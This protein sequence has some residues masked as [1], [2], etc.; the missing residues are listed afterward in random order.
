MVFV[1]PLLFW[2]V[3]YVDVSCYE[4]KTALAQFLRVLTCLLVGL[5]VR[6]LVAL[7]FFDFVVVTDQSFE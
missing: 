6:F 7:L 5:L 1:S 2:L 4:D 3:N